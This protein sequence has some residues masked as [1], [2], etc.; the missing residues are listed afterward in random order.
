MLHL[1][2]SP[3]SWGIAGA[4]LGALSARIPPTRRGW[5]R[6]G[7]AVG[8]SVTSMSLWLSAPLGAN[9]LVG[10]L[11]HGH[12]G[13]PVCGP[14]QSGW[15]VVVLSGG[16][17]RYPDEVSA[18]E[19]LSR[20]SVKRLMAGMATARGDATTGEA[21][22]VIS[23]GPPEPGELAESEVMAWWA[24]QGGWPA[25]R[26]RTETVSRNT[27]E[28]ARSLAT[29]TPA[30]P[31]QVRLVTSALHLP[32]A[33][34]AMR[35]HGFDVCA[36]PA[37]ATWVGP[38]DWGYL[39]PQSSALVKAEAALHEWVGLIVQRWRHGEAPVGAR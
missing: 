11:E 7:I 12:G 24:R 29:L 18:S 33:V 26:L 16:F 2:L 25:E 10:T 23:G 13:A 17:D 36:A 14:A 3:L 8:L 35:W 30:L 21:L 38:G 39:V 9:V 1:L 6:T 22:L 32:R 31:R 37:D 5:R 28:N 27:W 19:S 34:H 4:L 15:P 20:A